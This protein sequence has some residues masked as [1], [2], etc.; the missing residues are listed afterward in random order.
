MKAYVSF[1]NAWCERGEA[2]DLLL[3]SYE[4]MH[5]NAERVLADVC[6]FCGVQV[7]NKSIVR[8]VEFGSIG[9]MGKMGKA[10]IPRLNTA[11]QVTK[12]RKG[13]IGDYLNHLSPSDIAYCSKHIA[14]LHATLV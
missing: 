3:V 14:K 8:A 4:S 7:K 2:T 11:Y 12:I 6:A 5:N 10:K 1:Y 13:I 9:N